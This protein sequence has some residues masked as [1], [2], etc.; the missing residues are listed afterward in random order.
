[1]LIKDISRLTGLSYQANVEQFVDDSRSLQLFAIKDHVWMFLVYENLDG[2]EAQLPDVDAGLVPDAP[3]EEQV[4]QDE[5]ILDDAVIGWVDVVL[6][7]TAVIF[8]DG[9][10]ETGI[11]QNL[12]GKQ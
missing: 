4:T 3:V 7:L 2:L 12:K 5:G 6:F 1:M 9:L 11:Q 8:H 10:T